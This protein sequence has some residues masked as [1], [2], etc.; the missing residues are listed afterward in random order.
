MRFHPETIVVETAQHPLWG[1]QATARCPACDSV[2]LIAGAAEGGE[3][4]AVRL[5][6]TLDC[7]DEP[8]FVMDA[9]WI[10][11]F[12]ALLFSEGV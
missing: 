4:E 6:A 9:T 7:G 10:A 1:P 8:R 3:R 5:L 11:D 12:V 2:V